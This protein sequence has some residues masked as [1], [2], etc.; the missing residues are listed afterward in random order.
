[1][2]AALL[3]IAFAMIVGT[4]IGLVAAQA[5]PASAA[6]S[7]PSAS[8]ASSEEPAG[9]DR[10]ATTVSATTLRPGDRGLQ[11]AALQKSLAAS[12]Y[13]VGTADGH[14][15]QLTQQAVLAFQKVHG[16]RR[17]GIYGP[18]TRAALEAKPSRPAARSRSGLVVEIDK[19]RQVLMVVRN[20]RV[21]QI[22]NTSTGSGARYLS[23]GRATIATTPSGQFTV[24]RQIDGVRVSDLGR[25]YRPKYF[26]G[27]IAIHGAPSIPGYPA[28]HGCARL[29]N[30]AID[31]MWSGNRI[32]V[33]TPVSVH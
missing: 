1:M 22:F 25:L 20:G 4:G 33:G 31:W 21:E 29:T 2:R 14:Y 18:A 13:W 11:V 10:T 6:S 30:A 5:P 23:H 27:G 12:G 32:P 8:S 17:D 15:G 26:N 16:L 24:Y 28:S 9:P 19:G 7:G 3:V